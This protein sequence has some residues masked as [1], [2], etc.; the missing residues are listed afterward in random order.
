VKLKPTNVPS[1]PLPRLHGIDDLRAIETVALEHRDLPR[2]TWEIVDQAADARP[3]DPANVWVPD[4]ANPERNIRYSF[5]ELR[6]AVQRYANVYSGLGLD[7]SEAVAFLT[8]NVSRLLP[9]ILGAQAAGIAAPMNPAF[10]ID[11]LTTLLSTTGARVVVAAGPEFG[12]DRWDRL[13]SRARRMGAKALLA[14][15]PDDADTPAPALGAVRGLTVLYLD[16]AAAHVTSDGLA[17][18]PP[19]PQDIAAYFHT[20]GTTGAPKVAA[21]T[22]VNEAFLAWDMATSVGFRPGDAILAGLPLFHVN[23]LMVTGLAPILGGVTSVWPGP[24]GWRDPALLRN[25]W[26]LIEHFGITAMS[27]VPT[28]YAGLAALEVDA[29]ISTLR[30]PI[31]GAAPLPKP[32]ATAFEA[33]TGVSLQEGYG[34]TE[35]GCASTFTL[36]SAGL[37]G[38]VGQRMPYQRVAAASFDD[39]GAITLLPTGTP[40]EIVI[41]GPTV[42]AGYV[43][44]SDSRRW[45]DKSSIV[46]GWLR[47]GDLGSIDSEDRVW[48]TGRSKDLIIRGGHNI[49]PTIIE[50]ALLMH[51]HVRAAAAIGRPDLRAGEVPIGFVVVDPAY[52]G[53]DLVDWVARQIDEPA[54]RPVTIEMLPELP[55]TAVG[56]TFKPALHARTV[57]ALIRAR[58]DEIGATVEA[59]FTDNGLLIEVNG[60]DVVVGTARATL[61]ELAIDAE[62]THHVR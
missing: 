54:A 6:L 1:A 15:R 25:T 4:P 40:G 38:C 5:A 60:S 28:V 56:K 37:P 59:Q 19:R 44:G 11:R 23:G 24:L 55:L 30:T 27:G 58:I 26:R 32:V 29:A 9:A 3:D 62:V 52:E 18:T 48:I 7:R 22:H 51:P 33:R 8:P 21:H 34:L 31:V 45:L 10:E 20:G 43:K 41:S 49:D 16:D 53:D 13:R 17:C 35:A 39:A 14:L 2:T 47:T 50:E 36:A 46:D 61:K 42:F 57:A 12:E